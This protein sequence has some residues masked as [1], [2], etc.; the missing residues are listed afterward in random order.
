MA[1]AWKAWAF[2]KRDLPLALQSRK[3]TSKKIQHFLLSKQLAAALGL[4]RAEAAAQ[5][6]C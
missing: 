5:Q 4:R 6:E 3:F 2:F 1:V